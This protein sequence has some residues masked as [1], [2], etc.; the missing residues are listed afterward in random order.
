[1]STKANG[2]TQQEVFDRMA[3]GWYSRRHWTIFRKE[4]E[5]T[6]A[7]WQSG[8]LLNV[9][10][11]HGADF[12]PFSEG[13]ELYGIDFSTNMLENARKYARKFKFSVELAQADISALPFADGAF[14][15]AIAVATYHHLATPAEREAALA[16]LHRVLKPG[17]GA[18]VTVWNRWQP[19]FWLRPKDVQVRWKTKDRELYRFYHLFSRREIERAVRDA[20]FTVV[21]S[22]P[23]YSY[24]F[25]LHAFSHNNCLLLVKKPG[26]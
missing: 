16:D 19:A 13:F 23:E 20:G 21:R 2:V 5:D 3:P 1:M 6:A 22:F 24:R 12:L 10:C 11:G 17:G 4:L 25:P 18:F 9:G 7:G 26:P 15:Y 14:D 8:R